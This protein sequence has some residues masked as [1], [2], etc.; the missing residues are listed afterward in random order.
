MRREVFEGDG[1]DFHPHCL[2]CPLVVCR[3]DVVGGLQAALNLE[4]DAEIWKLHQA[5]LTPEA[6]AEQVRFSLRTVQKVLLS[7][8]RTTGVRRTP[9]HNVPA[10]NVPAMVTSAGSAVRVTGEI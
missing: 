1:C 7:V 2:T 6:I 4:R 9:S 8:Y 3:Y 5:G 10:L